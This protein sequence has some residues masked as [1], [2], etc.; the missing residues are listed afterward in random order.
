MSVASLA[1]AVGLLAAKFG[2]DILVILQEVVNWPEDPFLPGWVTRHDRGT[3]VAALWPQKLATNLHSAWYSGSGRALGLRFVSTCIAGCY[4]PDSW[5]SKEEYT[6]CMTEVDAVSSHGIFL[7]AEGFIL[8]GDLN[9]RM[10]A[11]VP[12]CTGTCTGSATATGEEL[13]RQEVLLKYLRQW[14]MKLV[15]TFGDARPLKDIR[16]FHHLGRHYDSVIDFIGIP[17]NWQA[18][19]FC[20]NE[21]VLE[22]EG[23]RR[24]HFPLWMSVRDE[25][26]RINKTCRKRT[27]TG[28]KPVDEPQLRI[29]QARLPG[30]LHR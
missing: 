5:K 11:E 21:E 10:P 9:V 2:G 26:L 1:T 18:R 4:L 29:F 13:W 15:N 8:A 25:T 16:T 14:E 12:G 7:G 20:W 22:V 23:C 19:H 6:S 24:D 28:W 17:K 3:Y 30:D 27:L